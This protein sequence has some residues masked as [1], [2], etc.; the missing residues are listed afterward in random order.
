[1]DREQIRREGKLDRKGNDWKESPGSER[2]KKKKIEEERKGI[3]SRFWKKK[4]ESIKE[5]RRSIYK[6]ISQNQTSN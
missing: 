1:M 6:Q 4:K 5:E 2:K 3:M